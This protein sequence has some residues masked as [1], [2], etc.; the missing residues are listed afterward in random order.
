LTSDLQIVVIAAAPKQVPAAACNAAVAGA[1]TRYVAFQ[2]PGANGDVAEVAQQVRVLE[3]HPDWAA[4]CRL[5]SIGDGGAIQT[6]NLQALIEHTP[7]LCLSGAVIR[8]S[9]L[10]AVGGFDE[11]LRTGHDFD[12]WLRLARRGGVIGGAASADQHGAVNA[13]DDAVGR[14]ESLITVLERFAARYLVDQPTRT[15]LRARIMWLIDRLEIE[16]AKCRM[17]EGHFDAARFH[18]ASA[19]RPTWRIRMALAALRLTPRLARVVYR[20]APTFATFL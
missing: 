18:L 2:D 19:R 4:I 5:R 6:F 13:A 10:T 17:L 12:L 1:T 7:A 20:V 3:E 14:I 15:A 11:G 8:R 16:Q 9:E